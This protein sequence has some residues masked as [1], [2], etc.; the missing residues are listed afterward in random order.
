MTAATEA[1]SA[2][3]ALG[4]AYYDYPQPMTPAELRTEAMERAK[5]E[6]RMARLYRWEH[7]STMYGKHYRPLSF[8]H[9]DRAAKARAI[10]A[11]AERIA[12]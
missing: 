10:Y 8:I 11:N 12:G 1:R 2:G 6:L 3:E 5:D 9:L 7:Y 4:S